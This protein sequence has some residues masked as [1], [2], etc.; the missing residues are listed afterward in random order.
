MKA[1]VL[2]FLWLSFLFHTSSCSSAVVVN[3]A[4]TT[5]SITQQTAENQNP[6][7]V[8]D[9]SSQT[10]KGSPSQNPQDVVLFDGKNYIKKTGWRV[11]SRKEAFIEEST[12]GRSPREGRTSTG[13][14]VKTTTTQYIYKTPWHYS[15]DFYFDGPDLDYMEGNLEAGYFLEISVDGKVFMYMISGRKIVPPSTSNSYHEDPFVY[16]IQD[17]NGDGIL[18]TLVGGKAFGETIV[19]NWVL[20]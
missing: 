1:S 11:P 18:E 6:G 17:N 7:N 19:P 12:E 9:Q 3:N 4:A 5:N 13:K 8:S 14:Q 16:E 15:Q 10:V 20:N 2:L